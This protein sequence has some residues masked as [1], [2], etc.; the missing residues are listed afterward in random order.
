VFS[1]LWPSGS[2]TDL[3]TVHSRLGR[4]SPFTYVFVVNHVDPCDVSESLDSKTEVTGGEQDTRSR[5]PKS[6]TIERGHQM[7]AGWP[8]CSRLYA[9]PAWDFSS[10]KF[11]ADFSKVI[12]IPEV[13]P[14]AY[15]QKDHTRTFERSS[16]PCQSL[17]DCGHWHQNNP[18]YTESVRVFIIYEVRHNTAEEHKETKHI[19][20]AFT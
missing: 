17:G 8:L 11:R 6:G 10:V 3:T 2:R 14:C 9:C 1:L 5:N 20:L 16:N 18:A 15:T 7:D 13:R 4:Q 12:R 19:Y